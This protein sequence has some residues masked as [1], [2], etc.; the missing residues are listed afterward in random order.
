M[1]SGKSKQGKPDIIAP[2]SLANYLFTEEQMEAYI[3]Q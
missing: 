1:F 2:K 3:R